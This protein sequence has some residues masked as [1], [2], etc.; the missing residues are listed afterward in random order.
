[1]ELTKE[2]IELIL[3]WKARADSCNAYYDEGYMDI[4]A[5]NEL[6]KKLEEYIR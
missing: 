3:E 5:N 1:M 2:E 4:N 6:E